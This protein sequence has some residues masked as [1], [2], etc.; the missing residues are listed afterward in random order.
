MIKCGKCKKEFH[1][2]WIGEEKSFICRFCNGVSFK[3][4]NDNNLSEALNLAVQAL[5]K[6]GKH[7]ALGCGPK[8]DHDDPSWCDDGCGDYGK[9]ARQA[10]SKIKILLD[11]E[12]KSK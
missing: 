1:C 11:P 5:I 8:G 2:D 10:L 6:Y 4:T 3:Q 9:A 7:R 12:G